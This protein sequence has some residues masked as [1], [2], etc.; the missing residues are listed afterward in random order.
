MSCRPYEG[1]Y[2]HK[3]SCYF[4]MGELTETIMFPHRVPIRAPLEMRVLYLTNK[5]AFYNSLKNLIKKNYFAVL[6]FLC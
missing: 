2:I 1:F 4:T 6:M 5:Y 3:G